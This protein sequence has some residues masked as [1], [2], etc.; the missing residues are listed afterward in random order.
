[1]GLFSASQ[2]DMLDW[3]VFASGVTPARATA[4][5]LGLSL[6][7]PT[8]TSA[9]EVGTGTGLTRQTMFFA[10]STA[11]AGGS[12]TASNMSTASFGTANA[13]V[14]VSGFL[15]CDNV[16]SSASG[17]KLGGVLSAARTLS[18][19]DSITFAIASIIC[20]QA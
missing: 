11:V 4:M 10:P 15:L 20:T 18:S 9:S 3:I 6:G 5:A 2:K 17:I 1:M 19:G 12:A 14:T 16:A 8:S 7:S 13:A